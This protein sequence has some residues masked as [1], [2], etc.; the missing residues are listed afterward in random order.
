M[1]NDN[2]TIFRG[3][4]FPIAHLSRTLKNEIKIRKDSNSIAGGLAEFAENKTTGE[5]T[6]LPHC[7]NI[8]NI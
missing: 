7:C 6:H 4:E 3:H 2:Q 1:Y 8:Y 5:Y